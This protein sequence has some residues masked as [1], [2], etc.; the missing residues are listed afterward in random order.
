ML[1]CDTD[2]MATAI[3]ECF[4]WERGKPFI[5]YAWSIMRANSSVEPSCCKII[6]MILDWENKQ[7]KKN[8]KKNRDMTVLLNYPIFTVHISPELA[9]SIH[10]CATLD[11]QTPATIS[12]EKFN[13]K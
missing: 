9:V 3:T 4:I 5:N 8:N 1:S 6:K 7:T 10:N 13:R 11:E 12:L 2:V